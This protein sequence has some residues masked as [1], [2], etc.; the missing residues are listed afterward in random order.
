MDKR[1]MTIDEEIAYERARLKELQQKKELEDAKNARRRAEGEAFSA[2]VRAS[3]AGIGAVMGGAMGGVQARDPI[4]LK[5]SEHESREEKEKRV[6]P[7]R[8]N[9]IDDVFSN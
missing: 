8:K 4:T 3:F 7:R 9:Y 6:A 5:P 1:K 2:K